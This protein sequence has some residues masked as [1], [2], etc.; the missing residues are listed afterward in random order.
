MSDETFLTLFTIGF[1][2]FLVA[3]Y[4][5]LRLVEKKYHAQ[6][7]SIRKKFATYS[8]PVTLLL[9]F[10]ISIF[11]SQTGFCAPYSKKSIWFCDYTWVLL[12]ILLFSF[13]ISSHYWTVYRAGLDP[14]D[15]ATG[16]GFKPKKLTIS[17]LA[18]GIIFLTLFIFSIFGLF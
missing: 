6:I 15:Q 1:S 17:K 10:G 18:V 12:P 8:V 5:V 7:S 16:Q 3:A 4:I 9:I 11:S 14:L 13:A 2:V